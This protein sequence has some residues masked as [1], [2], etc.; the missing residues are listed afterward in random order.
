MRRVLLVLLTVTLACSRFVPPT[1]VPPTS[2]PATPTAVFTAS[3]EPTVMATAR[4]SA[5]ALPPTATAL[6]PSATPEPTSDGIFRLDRG[7]V[8]FQPGPNLYSGDIVSV[9]VLAEG[10]PLGWQ[11]A[12]VTLYAGSVDTPPLATTNFGRFGIGGRAQATFTWVWNTAGLEG[13]QD[14]VIVVDPVTPEGG[15]PLAQQALTVT[16]ELLPAASRPMPEREAAWARAE[17]D[18]CIFHYLAGTA[19]D[20]DIEVIKAEAEAAFS[21][22]E[23]MLGVAVEQKVV[24]TLL[25]RLLGHGGFAAGEISLTYIDRNPANSELFNLFAHEGTHILDR[26]IARTRPTIMTEGL[27]VYVAGGHFKVEDLPRRAAA[28]LALD[29]YIPLTTLANAFY[30]SQHEIGYLEAGSFIQYLVDRFGWERFRAM[31]ASFESAQTDAQ[32]LDAGL[33]LH[34][35][36][37]LESLEADWLAELRKLPREQDQMDDLRLTVELFDT[38][39]AYQRAWDSSAY[40]MY[41]WLPDGPEGRRRSIV[42]DFVRHPRAVENIVLE[43]MLVAAG[44]ALRLD[45]Y[46]V[47]EDLL[48]AVNSVLSAGSLQADPLAADYAQLVTHLSGMGYEA[49]TIEV[50][51]QTAAVTAIRDWP[52][53]EA[54]TMQRGPQGWQVAAGGRIGAADDWAAAFMARQLFGARRENISREF[55]RIFSNRHEKQEAEF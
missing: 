15:E 24:F 31:Y 19:A 4:P 54:L 25:S 5:T 6:P 53:L 33:Q 52:A 55:S 46:A 48:A 1:S 12:P 34:F 30:P 18:C 14:L 36:Q 29:R 38:L 49:Q 16:V 9:E 2:V 43:T 26:Q 7:D 39:R 47:T 17:T 40:F 44:D 8:R 42:G 10:A 28:L 21:H 13:P 32:M 50:D 27:A 22:I 35:G 11:G 51:G 23:S 45:D 3:P 20:R 37:S 41:A